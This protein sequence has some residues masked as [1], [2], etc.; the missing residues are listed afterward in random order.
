MIHQ[1]TAALIYQEPVFE[2]FEDGGLVPS[3]KALCFRRTRR[4]QASGKAQSDG[5]GRLFVL[6]S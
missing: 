1:N 6:G 3:T 4:A 5:E 2:A